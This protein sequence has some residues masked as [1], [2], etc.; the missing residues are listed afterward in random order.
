METSADTIAE[1]YDYGIQNEASDI[2]AHVCVRVRRCYAYPTKKGLEVMASYPIAYASQFGADGPTGKGH[3]VPWDAIPLLL[4][5]DLDNEW[6][7]GFT[8]N[9][10]HDEKGLRAQSIA[11]RLM[12]LG[13]FPLWCNGEIVT[14]FKA[15][16]EGE[17]I[18]AAGKWRIQVKCDFDGGERHLGGTGNL[19]LQIAERNPFKLI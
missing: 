10:P 17:D 9:L 18:T 5:C 12:K 2:R 13:R 3:K 7:L 4:A 16:M 6:L 15:Q 8:K 1:L 14:D 11:R 19:F